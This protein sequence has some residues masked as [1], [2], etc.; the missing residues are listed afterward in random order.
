MTS[1]RE[2]QAE[3][4]EWITRNFGNDSPLA[5]AGGLGEEGSEALEAAM[6]LAELA[7]LQVTIGRVLRGAVKHSQG[8]RGTRED[9]VREIRKECADV[10]I[11][12]TDVAQFYGFELEDAVTERWALVQQ[13]VNGERAAAEQQPQRESPSVFVDREYLA[14]LETV[15]NSVRFASIPTSQRR[16]ILGPLVARQQAQD[17]Q[18]TAE[19]IA[20][21]ASEVLSRGGDPLGGRS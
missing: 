19:A 21:V 6:G 4:A 10:F 17:E 18:L 14:A 8:I 1:I 2:L 12:L 20:T 13:R 11:K 7:G 15:A 9:W 5:T 16:L 3:I